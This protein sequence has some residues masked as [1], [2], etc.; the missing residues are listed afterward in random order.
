MKRGEPEGTERA[1][2]EREVL[3]EWE[4]VRAGR[5]RT[6]SRDDVVADL[7]LEDRVHG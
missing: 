5:A 4:D 2:W 3:S 7:G 1:R 6:Y